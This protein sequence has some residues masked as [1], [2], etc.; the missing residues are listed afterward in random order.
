MITAAHPVAAEQ[1]M[2][3]LDGEL[4]S[5]EA[6]AVSAHLEHCAECAELAGQFRGVSRSLAGWVVP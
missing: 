4:P 2:A 6:L 1:L 3:L 5:D